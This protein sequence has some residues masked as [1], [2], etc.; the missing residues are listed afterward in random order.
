MNSFHM[1]IKLY[2]IIYGPLE[3]SINSLQLL[4]FLFYNNNTVM[5]YSR[6]YNSKWTNFL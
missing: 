1:L 3:R 5:S 2:P 6:F 4:K